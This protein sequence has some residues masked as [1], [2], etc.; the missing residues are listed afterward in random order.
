MY[1]NHIVTTQLPVTRPITSYSSCHR[2]YLSMTEGNLASIYCHLPSG[3]I[4]PPNLPLDQL[5]HYCFILLRY[6]SPEHTIFIQPLPL[7][8]GDCPGHC[9]LRSINSRAKWGRQGGR[10]TLWPIHFDDYQL[11]IEFLQSFFGFSRE[12]FCYFAHNGF[13]VME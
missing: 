10:G 12:N 2:G 8:S 7:E 4:L 1:Y 3:L 13:L 9:G 5:S 11:N 6:H